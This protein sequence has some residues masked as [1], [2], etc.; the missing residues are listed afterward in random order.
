MR[1][2][3]RAGVTAQALKDR[4]VRGVGMT[5]GAGKPCV[6]AR[7]DREPCVIEGPLVPTGVSWPVA[8]FAGGREAGRL[9]IGVGGLIVLRFM[10]SI[11]GAG[12]TLVHV[13]PVACAT[14]SGSVQPDQLEESVVI[15]FPL[16]PAAVRG[17]VT[18]VAARRESGCLM[19][20][21]RC[22]IVLCLVAAVAGAGRARVLVALVTG[23][24]RHSGVPSD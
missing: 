7:F 15:E 17:L 8:R 9:V 19:V 1:I 18:V 10:A 12:C 3:L 11:A 24:A 6:P 2:D 16:V 4:V 5:G 23:R 21:I 20:R 22:L 14:R 13:A